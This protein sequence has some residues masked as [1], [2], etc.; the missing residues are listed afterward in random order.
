MK[1]YTLDLVT[2]ASLLKRSQKRDDDYEPEFKRKYEVHF[3]EAGSSKVKELKVIDFKRKFLSIKLSLLN[4]VVLDIL[5][6]HNLC[7]LE[8]VDCVIE[9]RKLAGAL[10]LMTR[11]ESLTFN[12]VRFD[13]LQTETDIKPIPLKLKNL[14]IWDSQTEIHKLISTE[15]LQNFCYHSNRP[16][17]DI[18]KILKK[19]KNLKSLTID[20][21]H[22]KYFLVD[23]EIL[24][25]P[26]KLRKFKFGG[27]TMGEEEK[28][29]DAAQPFLS[30]HKDTLEELIISCRI[31][32]PFLCFVMRNMRK[33]RVLEIATSFDSERFCV[34]LD[35]INS[36]LNNI[37]QLTALNLQSS[38]RRRTSS[39]ESFMRCFPSLEAFNASNVP[40]QETTWFMEFLVH[41]SRTYPDLQQLHVQS[42]AFSESLES[43]TFPKLKELHVNSIDKGMDNV[44]YF[45]NFV[46][47]HKE[48]LEKISIRRFEH[49]GY[50]GY[51]VAKVLNMCPKLKHVSFPFEDTIYKA[52]PNLERASHSSNLSPFSLEFLLERNWSRRNSE[53]V[54]FR[55][56]DDIA[57]W[58]QECSVWDEDLIREFGYR[59]SY[60]YQFK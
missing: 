43:L 3:P 46:T 10:E 50:F 52:F 38:T 37:K 30:L 13:A 7:S 53:K 49:V 12:N 54:V 19:Q 60:V 20:G 23:P 33:L 24:N 31:N 35:D 25:Y 22:S 16:L 56:P 26:F 5:K 41:I 9:R 21:N 51:D 29:I 15:T 4:D 36:P 39:A 27:T 2:G 14:V 1:N 42:I 8:V 34:N 59:N 11:L 58:R 44:N 55:F 6:L 40:Q 57:L 28:L 45:N 18:S 48:T 32:K 17:D 47:R